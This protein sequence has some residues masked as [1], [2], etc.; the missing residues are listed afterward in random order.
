MKKEFFWLI[1]SCI[2]VLSLI[3]TSCGTKTTSTATT[4]TTPTTKTLEEPQY[5]GTFVYRVKQDAAHLDI[6]YGISNI[7]IETLWFETLAMEDHTVEQNQWDFKTMYTPLKYWTGRLAESWETPDL[8]TYIFHIRKGVK[9]QN[10]EPVNGRELT[11]YDAEFSWQ[12]ILGLGSGFTKPPTTI[13]GNFPFVK[14]VTATD[15]YTLVFKTTQPSLDQ[16]RTILTVNVYGNVVPREAVEKWGDLEDWRHAIG[17]GPYILTDYVSSSSYSLVKNQDYWGYDE[18]HPQNRLPY[19]DEVS[20]LIIPDNAT[21]Y[22]AL[23]TG[24]IDLVEDV[25]WEQAASLGR[26][27]PNLLQAPRPSDSVAIYMPFDQK[28]YSDFKVRRAMQ[29]AID[30]NTIA[31]THY[32]GTIDGTPYGV[33]GPSHKGYYT[34]YDQWPDDVKAGYTYNPEGAMKL[35]SEAGYPDGFQTNVTV[36][37]TDDLDLFQIIKSYFT[38]INID[39]EINV[40]DPVAK[41][42]FSKSDKHLMLSG[43]GTQNLP[44]LNSITLGYTGHR[45][46]EWTHIE[47]PAYDAIYLQAKNS[48]DEEELRKL[49]IQANDYG[50]AHQWIVNILPFNYYCIYQPW[51][52]RY[53][54]E[55]TKAI[56]LGPLVRRIWIDQTLKKSLGY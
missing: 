38:D 23:R 13:G 15:E 6:Y 26:T 12:R 52:K 20:F 30:L 34:P 55:N 41:S 37:T 45:S 32:G 29:M 7:G 21:A 1:L 5:G 16:F 19:L 35:L 44:P 39:M 2:L 24:K 8:S 51:L 10:I 43:R 40:M 31:Q 25:D 48:L 36:A 42:A 11:A 18:L 28:P 54:G 47:D 49:I 14:S 27:N 53:N 17:T 3:L 46:Y 4:K 33:V 9:W 56:S 22:A 50:I